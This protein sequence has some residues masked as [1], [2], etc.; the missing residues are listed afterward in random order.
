MIK[1]FRN[2]RKAL[3]NEGKT[4]KYLKYAI[5][6]IILVM[7]GILLAIQVNN[8]NEKR[9]QSISL[10]KA[11]R[12]VM[13]DLMQ[14]E[15]YLK[16]YEDTDARRIEYLEAL[17]KR[18]Y[19]NIML[20]SILYNLDH[21]IYMYK[22]DNA[23]S[24]LKSSGL[25]SVIKNDSLKSNLTSYYEQIYDQLK[26]ITEFGETFT[27]DRIVPFLISN[28][29]WDENRLV[30]ETLVKE[31]IATTNLLQLTKYQIDVKRYSFPFLTNA[32]TLINTLRIE[33]EKEIDNL[34]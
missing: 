24:T 32:L 8:W 14:D 4:T 30:D 19:H 11:L 16:H 12:Q 31:K 7:I 10:E 29:D 21:Y 17:S 2:I 9:I 20:D 26:S 34:K 6:E 5:G 25:F 27:N 15:I 18:N 33:I 28:F 22:S 3:L 1:F 13:N 23:Y